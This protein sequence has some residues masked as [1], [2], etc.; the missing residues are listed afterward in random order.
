[1]KLENRL[2]QIDV[3]NFIFYIYFGIIILS[4]YANKLEKHYL[5]F[6]DNQSKEKYR[7]IMILIF[8]IAV[9]VYIDEH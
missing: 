9:C 3:E 5:I 7:N 6:K 4:L 2:K 1:M 8:A